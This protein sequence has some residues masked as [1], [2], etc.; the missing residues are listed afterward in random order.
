MLRVLP[1]A[2]DLAA[3]GAGTRGRVIEIDVTGRER[4]DGDAWNDG[5]AACSIDGFVEPAP[6]EPAVA[7]DV[8]AG[9]AVV[10][11]LFGRVLGT[12]SSSISPKKSSE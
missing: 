8:A 2:A 10:S 7:A 11:S 1:A 6:F 12:P 4:N 9:L 3:E 5:G